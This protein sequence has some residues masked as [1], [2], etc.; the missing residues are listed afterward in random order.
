MLSFPTPLDHFN[1]Y[2]AKQELDAQFTEDIR[3]VIGGQGGTGS[4]PRG[5]DVGRARGVRA[6]SP[7]LAAGAALSLGAPVNSSSACAEAYNFAR[8]MKERAM[9]TGCPFDDHAAFVSREGPPAAHAHETVSSLVTPSEMRQAFDSAH[10][11]GRRNRESQQKIGS[12]APF[13]APE[14]SMPASSYRAAAEEATSG[15]PSAFADLKREAVQNRNRMAGQSDLISGGY[16]NGE[17]KVSPPVGRSHG[18]PQVE[19]PL[20]QAILKAQMDNMG[21]LSQGQAAFLN[22]K[23]MSEAF[24]ERNTRGRIQFG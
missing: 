1:R 8:Q 18:P 6:R 10:S 22:A 12:A 4:K 14:R 23:V 7:G 13:D 9:G 3:R 21:T 16:L 2:N 19:K 20:P 11:V 17:S 24:R 15:E 5:D